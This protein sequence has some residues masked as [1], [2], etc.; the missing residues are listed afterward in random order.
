MKGQD[1]VAFQYTLGLSLLERQVSWNISKTK[2][3]PE[4]QIGMNSGN[5][6]PPPLMSRFA[7]HM[8]DIRLLATVQW[9]WWGWTWY[10]AIVTVYGVTS[11]WRVAGDN[12]FN[13]KLIRRWRVQSTPDLNAFEMSLGSK[14]PKQ[15]KCLQHKEKSN[16]ITV[17]LIPRIG[18]GLDKSWD[19]PS[20]A[21]RFADSRESPNSRKSCQG[22]RAEP[23]FVRIAL[24][25]AKKL[26][27]A[28]LR[29]FARMARTVENRVFS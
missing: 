29:R 1:R 2:Y 19:G 21:N 11:V 15:P 13:S 14:T 27:I 18:L 26:R 7:T 10:I 4:N 28:G 16:T 8:E 5:K 3:T 12:G 24:R 20:R 17:G 25:G 6:F 23:L 9:C 22:S